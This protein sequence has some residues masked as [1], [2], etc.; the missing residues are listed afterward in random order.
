MTNV[1]DNETA[2]E[3]SMPFG[4]VVAQILVNLNEGYAVQPNSALHKRLAESFGDFTSA[5]QAVGKIDGSNR[6]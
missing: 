1:F 3:Q 5:L 6:D 4:A 2:R